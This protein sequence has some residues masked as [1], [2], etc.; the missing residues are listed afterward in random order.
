MFT[1]IQRESGTRMAVIL[2]SILFSASHFFGKVRIPAEQVTAWSG[3]GLI[4]GALHAFADPLGI[5][6]AFLCRAAGGAGR[7]GGRA[8]AGGGAGAR[9]RRAGGGGGGGGAREGT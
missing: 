5:A 3:V 6:D 7:A 4:T 1:A 2:T 9:G 8:G